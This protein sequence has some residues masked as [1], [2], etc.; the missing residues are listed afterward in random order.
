[1]TCLLDTHFLVWIVSNS[2][3]IKNY[4]WLQDYQ[5]WSISPVSLLEIQLLAEVGRRHIDNPR[6]TQEVMAD[7]RFQ[8]DDVSVA[9]LLLRSLELSWT[10]D[11]FDRLIASHSLLRRVPLCSVDSVMLKHHKHI[12]PELR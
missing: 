7:L 9:A 4:P 1:M 8:L 2:S 3:R 6:F 5:P 10:R 12:V 11:P